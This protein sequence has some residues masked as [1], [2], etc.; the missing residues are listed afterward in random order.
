MWSLAVKKI[1][2][3]YFQTGQ[4]LAVSVEVLRHANIVTGG[5]GVVNSLLH[6]VLKV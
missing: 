3:L 6:I 1:I 4:A 5:A 2:L